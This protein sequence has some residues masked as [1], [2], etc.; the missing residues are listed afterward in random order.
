[1]IL[2]A[3]QRELPKPGEHRVISRDHFIHVL[4]DGQKRVLSL[5]AEGLTV[6]QAAQRM[7]TS[8]SSV[9][10]MVF[11]AKAFYEV[12]TTAAA[13]ARWVREQMVKNHPGG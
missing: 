9:K 1:M 13:V 10:S 12:P 4:S 2:N 5:L 3:H 8:V 11:R 7:G 6:R